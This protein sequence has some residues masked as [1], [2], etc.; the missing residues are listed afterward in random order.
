MT[1]VA[2]NEAGDTVF[3][4]NVTTRE[5]FRCKGC[6]SPL[7]FCDATLKVKYFQHAVACNCETEPETPE[8]VFGK[9]LVFDALSN[10]KGQPEKVDMEEPVGRLKADVLWQNPMN[11]VA[12]EVQAANYKIS[13]FEEKINYYIRRKL[14][15]IYL[16]VGENFCKCL[17][18]CVYSLKAIEKQ[19]IFEKKYSDYV[20]GGYLE[21]NGKVM[22]PQF[23]KKYAHGGGE[24]ENRFFL[25][26]ADRKNCDLL[27]FLK[28]HGYSPPRGR[29][30]PPL[31]KHENVEYVLHEGKV[32]RYKTIC[33]DCRKF[34][35]WLKN[36]K[37]RALGLEL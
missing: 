30:S 7:Y 12:I 5:N 10:I 6:G 18:P 13:D 37:A 16:F 1:L 24:C 29:Y 3:A 26:W 19:I 20:V 25:G 32:K 34:V 35:C 8:H 4:K 28:H 33:A 9:Q 17:K 2:L 22:I 36:D 27:T 21:D 11:T 15:V 14:K 23:Q 31:C